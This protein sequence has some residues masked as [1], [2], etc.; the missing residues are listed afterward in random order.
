MGGT[1][2]LE[3]RCRCATAADRKNCRCP[4]SA[5]SWRASYYFRGRR[6]RQTF[7][8]KQL[9][10]RWLAEQMSSRA[11]GT[12]IDPSDGRTPFIEWA[13]EWAA[14]REAVLKRSTYLAEQGRLTKHLLPFFGAHTVGQISPAEV[15]R[16]IAQLDLAPKTV[17]HC[18][19]LLRQIMADAIAEG[20]I[21]K[22][23]CAGT[24][25]P[26]VVRR[27]MV[28]LTEQQL[29]QLY[30]V[31]RERYRPLVVTLA[32]TGMRFGEVAGL[33]VGRVDL[34][35]GT[36]RVEETLNQAHGKVTWSTPKT[37]AS[38]R[39]IRLPRRVVDELVPLVAARRSD[40]LVFT[41][42]WGR[43]VRERMFRDQIW[44]PAVEMLGW[45]PRPRVHDLRHTHAS[46]L[47]AKNV[48]LLAISRRLGHTSISVTADTYGHI[49]P[50]AE[51]SLVAAL[52]EGYETPNVPRGPLLAPESQPRPG[53]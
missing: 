11:T 2:G 5:V 13:T 50:S 37:R 17:R 20:M 31:I 34:L 47:I 8:R 44:G 4:I 1:G 35:A 30:G 6:I 51:D 41:T 52:D 25:L 26:E 12:H 33:R 24:R 23:P 49:L 28:V 14:S 19:S 40:E 27:E 48:P 10:E 7:S 22:N 39:T 29:E 9:A 16:W 38:R 36:V 45:S 46:H 53:S 21:S 32:M 43:P 15:R 42:R 18:H 3:K